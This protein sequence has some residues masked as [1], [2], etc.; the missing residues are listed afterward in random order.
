M[1]NCC[2]EINLPDLVFFYLSLY[3]FDFPRT[4]TFYSYKTFSLAVYSFTAVLPD[5]FFS[6]AYISGTTGGC[7]GHNGT[8]LENS[9]K[10]NRKKIHVAF[11]T[12]KR[13]NPHF[14]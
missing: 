6:S 3:D 9:K 14:R 4:D 8:G 11:T 12:S 13:I 2:L 10:E 1:E 5:A 7:F